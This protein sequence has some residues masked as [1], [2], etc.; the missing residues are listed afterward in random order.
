MSEI[1]TVNKKK[2]VGSFIIGL[3][4]LA[5]AITGVVSIGKFAVD[6]FYSGEEEIVDYSGYAEFL[7]WVVGVDPDSFSDITKADKNALLLIVVTVLYHTDAL[8]GT[9]VR[10]HAASL[11]VVHVHFQHDLPALRVHRRLVD[12]PFR[13]VDPAEHAPHALAVV[14]HR[15]E[16]SES[17][18]HRRQHAHAV[19]PADHQFVKAARKLEILVYLRFVHLFTP[20][21][22]LCTPLRPP[23][24]SSPQGRRPS[25]RPPL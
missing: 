8:R 1:V 24:C 6:K 12:A 21:L 5:L 7:T 14:E 11:A 3:L 4:V 13:A 16:C 15:M 18:V 17:R 23:P 20:P 25:C 22:P 2:K 19:A 10:A 9:L